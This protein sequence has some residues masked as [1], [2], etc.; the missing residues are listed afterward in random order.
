LIHIQQS[1]PPNTSLLQSRLNGGIAPKINALVL[2]CIDQIVQSPYS[3]Q[4]LVDSYED[5]PGDVADWS[6]DKKMALARRDIEMHRGFWG[7]LEVNYQLAAA[8][9]SPFYRRR[10]AEDYFP[11]GQRC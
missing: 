6:R 1:F 3:F 9:V 7:L 10:F 8:G 5:L 4:Q 11:R 2:F